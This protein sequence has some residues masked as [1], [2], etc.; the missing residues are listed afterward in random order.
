M[1]A[2]EVELVSVEA[3][4]NGDRLAGRQ[5][6]SG[7]TCS[8]ESVFAIESGKNVLA[9]RL[10]N[11]SEK[12]IR[13]SKLLLGLDESYKVVFNNR[14]LPNELNNH[15]ANNELEI[16]REKLGL[17]WLIIPPKGSAL[18]SLDPTNW[19]ALEELSGNHKEFQVELSSNLFDSHKVLLRFKVTL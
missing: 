8:F 5:E 11:G 19:R 9:V 7:I 6:Y 2:R 18:V 14:I 3:M 4:K 15:Q 17:R 16:Y 1:S 13:V 10:K 12:P